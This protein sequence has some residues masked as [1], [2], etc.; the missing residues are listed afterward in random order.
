MRTAKHLFSLVLPLCKD[1]TNSLSE[2]QCRI[3]GLLCRRTGPL[4][5]DDRSDLSRGA[6]AAH[7]RAQARLLVGGSYWNDCL[8]VRSMSAQHHLRRTVQYVCATVLDAL[9]HPSPSTFARPLFLPVE[10]SILF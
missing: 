1:A 8:A 10:G 9:V 5:D 6:G 7:G 4:A 2:K 3:D